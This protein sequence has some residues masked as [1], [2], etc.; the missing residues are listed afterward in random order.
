MSLIKPIISGDW[1]SGNIEVAA[2]RHQITYIRSI[3][4]DRNYTSKEIL[5]VWSVI[6]N[7]LDKAIMQEIKNNPK[8]GLEIQSAVRKCGLTL[9]K[10]GWTPRLG[11]S[12]WDDVELINTSLNCNNSSVLRLLNR[13][14]KEVLYAII[15]LHEASVGRKQGFLKAINYLHILE[16]EKLRPD[17]EKAKRSMAGAVKGGKNKSH[18]ED[19]QIFIDYLYEKAR[20]SNAKPKLKDILKPLINF[21]CSEPSDV[22]EYLPDLAEN[23]DDVFVD[24]KLLKL[25]WKNRYGKDAE[26]SYNTL[27]KYRIRSIEKFS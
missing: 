9:D 12:G 18:D 10:P 13:Q 11:V 25:K 16:K 20:E 4:N 23:F 1:L 19:L 21:S 2:Y 8:L 22:F 14:P 27:Y 17:A 6:D 5:D 3:L 15:A 26:A 7:A 24:K